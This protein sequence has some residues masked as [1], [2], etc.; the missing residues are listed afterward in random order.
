MRAE[1]GSVLSGGSRNKIAPRVNTGGVPPHVR[2]C[3]TTR[4]A[5]GERGK[6]IWTT[7]SGGSYIVIILAPLIGGAFHISMKNNDFARLGNIQGMP[8]KQIVARVGAPTS[9][10]STVDGQIYQRLSSVGGSASHYAIL[11]DLEGKAVGF[12]HQFST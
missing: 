8:I 7:P 10:S 1:H 5:S 6:H 9:I 4:L 3:S 2:T 11:V 12:T